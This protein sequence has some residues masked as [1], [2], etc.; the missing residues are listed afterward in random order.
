MPTD[1]N[2]AMVCVLKR[3][4]EWIAARRNQK[5]PPDVEAIKAALRKR[6]EYLGASY[7][8]VI[9]ESLENFTKVV[10]AH[11]SISPDPRWDQFR[12]QFIDQFGDKP[13]ANQ[14]RGLSEDPLW[15]QLGHE[16]RDKPWDQIWDKFNDHFAEQFDE[17]LF[18]QFWYQ[19]LNQPNIMSDDCLFQAM[20][21]EDDFKNYYAYFLEVVRAGAF[22]W[23]T[24]EAFCFVLLAP[25][26]HP[27]GERRLHVEWPDG[28][29]E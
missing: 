25:R 18:G 10:L 2:V 12:N 9:A 17:T 27:D 6:A 22:C 8:I 13:W 29:K 23:F 7:E 1:E 20:P 14:L 15:R 21:Q 3:A 4:E 26:Y 28:T 19:C 16:F 5:W 11:K 24:P